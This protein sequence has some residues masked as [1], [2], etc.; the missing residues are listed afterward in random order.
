MRTVI[1]QVDFP[2]L[3]NPPIIVRVPSNNPIICLDKK[4]KQLISSPFL[5]Y[6]AISK[7]TPFSS[8]SAHDSINS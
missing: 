3:L 1:H 7:G 8:P 6:P 4:G 2:A 5:S